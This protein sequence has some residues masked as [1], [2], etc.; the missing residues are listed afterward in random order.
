M[1]IKES[2]IYSFPKY[3]CILLKATKLYILKLVA[4][5]HC[6]FKK[7]I[8]VIVMLGCRHL[9]MSSMSNTSNWPCTFRVCIIC[10]ILRIVKFHVKKHSYRSLIKLIW[11]LKNRSQLLNIWAIIATC[12]FITW[13]SWRNCFFWLFNFS[14]LILFLFKTWIMLK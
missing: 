8:L 9:N 11:A 13:K 6:A 7:V 10:K 14:Y 5:L 2:T 1:N 3:W 12:F 4:I